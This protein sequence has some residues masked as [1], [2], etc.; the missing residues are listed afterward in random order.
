MRDTKA[1]LARVARR[2]QDGH[3]TAAEFAE[4]AGIEATSLRTMLLPD[5]SNRA[6]SNVEA[7]AGALPK[8]RRAPRKPPRPPK[9][10]KPRKRPKPKRS[11]APR[12]RYPSR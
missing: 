5:W 4:R 11:T 1:L 12:I 8:M 7:I 9:P 3:F 10:P 2:I 6:V